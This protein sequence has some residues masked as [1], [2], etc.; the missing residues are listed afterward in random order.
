[1]T[2]TVETTIYFSTPIR[3][4]AIDVTGHVEA[5]APAATDSYGRPTEMATSSDAYATYIEM[6]GVE[7][8]EEEICK[9]FD[10]DAKFWNQLV[11]EELVEAFE[12]EQDPEYDDDLPF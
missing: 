10:I 3:E 7:H 1:M 8:T 4:Y 9:F 11:F 6:S 5:G 2:Y 12:N